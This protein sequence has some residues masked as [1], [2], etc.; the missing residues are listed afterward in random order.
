MLTVTYTRIKLMP[1]SLLGQI[2]IFVLFLKTA[3]PLGIDQK[4]VQFK[5]SPQCY[6][7]SA[8]TNNVELP[9]IWI[10]SIL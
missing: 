2:K 7:L 6:G 9:F 8:K 1:K 10:L 3:A 4:C 5:Q